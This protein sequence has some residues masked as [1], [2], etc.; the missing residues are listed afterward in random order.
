[1]GRAVPARLVALI[2][3][4]TSHERSIVAAIV[5]GTSVLLAMTGLIVSG[6]VSVVGFAL[7]ALGRFGGIEAGLIGL[8]L[9]R[10]GGDR[11]ERR[12]R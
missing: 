7:L 11:D 10:I 2:V 4:G 9:V 8:G 1:L 12:G 5:G 3:R 6:T